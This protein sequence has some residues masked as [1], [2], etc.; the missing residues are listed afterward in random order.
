MLSGREPGDVDWQALGVDVVVE[1]TAHP[2]SR[3]EMHQH[4]EAGTKWV[5]LCVPPADEPDITVVMGV[6]DAQLTPAHRIIS[7]ASV[8]ANCAAPI[9]KLVDDAFGLERLFFTTVHAYTNDQRLADVPAQDLR[10]SRAATENI[11]PTDTNAARVLEQLLPHLAGR[12][13][14]MALNVPVLNG[15]LVDLTMFTQKPMTRT[16]V[17]EVVRTGIDAKFAKYVHDPIVS[18]DVKLSPYSCTFDSLATTQLGEHLVKCIAWYDNG[19]GYAHRVVDLI[20]RL[21][22]M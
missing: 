13:T 22:H 2:R 14:G 17:N 11:I 8:T 16:A 15:S 9:I 1:A 3:A 10:R 18:S 19:W 7:T 5:I 12:I 21:A 6:N 20:E 4:L